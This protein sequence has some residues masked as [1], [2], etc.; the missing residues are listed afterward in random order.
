MRPM[1]AGTEMTSENGAEVPAERRFTADELVDTEAERVALDALR[2]ATGGPDG[3][4]ERHCLRVFLLSDQ[5][6][7]QRGESVDREVMLVASLLHDI[8]LYKEVS[9]GGVYVRDGAEYAAELLGMHGWNADRIKLCMDAIE[10]HHEVRAQW[11]RGPEVELIRRADLIE[12]T[13]GLVRFGLPR[14][15]IKQLFST[16][17]RDG[18][19]REIGGEVGKLLL[20]R[21]HT[22]PGVFLRRG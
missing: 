2:I 15:Q 10:R 19:L 13:A 4:M 22:L 3:A 16:V 17:P 1:E 14:A 18:T 21:P 11:K 6:A 7:Q 9:R 12:V 20:T 5:M 8:G